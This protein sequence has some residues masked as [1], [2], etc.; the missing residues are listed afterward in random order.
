MNVVFNRRDTAMHPD[1]VK[2]P[3]RWG[4]VALALVSMAL[5]ACVGAGAV[6]LNRE[7]GVAFFKTEAAEARYMA[8]YDA[9]HTTRP[10]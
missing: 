8:A 9:V 10:V 4:R 5:V 2:A 7:G 1:T 6:W 3:K